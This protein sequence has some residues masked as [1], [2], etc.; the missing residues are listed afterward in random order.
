MKD[1]KAKGKPARIRVPALYDRLSLLWSQVH[2]AHHPG[3]RAMLEVEAIL[4]TIIATKDPRKLHA[5]L[6]ALYGIEVGAHRPRLVDASEQSVDFVVDRY[7][8]GKWDADHCRELL[9][10]TRADLERMLAE[11]D[12]REE[13]RRAEL[14]ARARAN[15]GKLSAADY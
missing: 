3:E 11:H 9:G 5:N 7:R 14:E 12:A 8:A 10:L 6:C 15:G 13:Q 4:E 1:R 2:R